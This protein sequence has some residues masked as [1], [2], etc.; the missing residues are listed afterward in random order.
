MPQLN[1]ELTGHSGQRQDPAIA[2]MTLIAA[3]AGEAVQPIWAQSKLYGL[4]PYIAACIS[5]SRG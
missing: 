3:K 5:A 4:V 1:L 2:Q